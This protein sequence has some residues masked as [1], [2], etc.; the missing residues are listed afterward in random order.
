YARLLSTY[1]GSRTIT[2]VSKALVNPRSNKPLTVAGVA[3]GQ[4]GYV[5]YFL[6]R[7]PD[8]SLEIQVG[9]ELPDQRIAWSFPGIGVV[10]S[11]FIDGETMQAGDKSYE[12]WHLYGIRPHADAATMARLQKELPARVDRWA[13]AGV[14]YCL[15]DAPGANC[16]SCLGLVLR[17]LFPGRTGDYPALPQ[18]FWH[19]GMGSRYTPNDLLLYLT[20]MLD[21]PNRNAR[22]QRINR[23]ELPPDLRLDLED[24]VHT[25]GTREVS[26]REALQKRPGAPQTPRRKL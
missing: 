4:A 15:E 20:G 19:A 6:L 23:L 21:L 7:M 3:P 9:I 14:P 16:M 8:E 24:L 22:L 1:P 2:L 12:V 13:K 17:A 25:M 18:N 11:L 10:V 26:P 5:H